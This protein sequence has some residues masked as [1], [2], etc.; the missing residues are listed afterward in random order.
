MRDNTFFQIWTT[1]KKNI[2]SDDS[3][4]EIFGIIFN[5]KL[6]ILFK[7]LTPKNPQ[8]IQKFRVRVR[9]FNKMNS[10]NNIEYY[11]EYSEYMNNF[12]DFE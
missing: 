5:I 8:I 11:S 12:E 7:I 2:D 6:F 1:V 4:S 3:Y 10:L 9:V